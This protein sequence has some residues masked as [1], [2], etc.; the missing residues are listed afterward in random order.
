MA[1]LPP[2]AGLSG[3]AYL[4][5]DVFSAGFSKAMLIAA[6]LTALGGLLGWIT[7]QESVPVAHEH[8]DEYCCALDAPPLRTRTAARG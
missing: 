4:N 1:V 8:T 5:P 6:G 7:L 2:I 3:T